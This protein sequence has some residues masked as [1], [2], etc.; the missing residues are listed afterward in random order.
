M[1]YKRY[2]RLSH[3]VIVSSWPLLTCHG[4]MTLK[5]VSFHL[6][7]T[8][9]STT[10]VWNQQI[11]SFGTITYSM[12][13]M[14]ACNNVCISNPRRQECFFFFLYGVM[15]FWENGG[16]E[17][18][19]NNYLFLCPFFSFLAFSSSWFS[20]SFFTFFISPLFNSFF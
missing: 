11:W 1:I 7:N 18:K 5:C 19:N 20:I 14:S 2:K 3:E 12:P 15:A 16:V 8:S 17:T 6:T 9:G 10:G 13:M 4:S